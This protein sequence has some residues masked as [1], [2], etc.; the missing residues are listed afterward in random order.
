MVLSLLHKEEGEAA[1]GPPWW[2][3]KKAAR[4]GSLSVPPAPPPLL[5]ASGNEAASEGCS[6]GAAP[7][8]PVLS[9][10]G[11]GAVFGSHIEAPN[12][13]SPTK[14]TCAHQVQGEPARRGCYHCH[15]HF[16]MGKQVQGD[17]PL[18]GGE[19]AIGAQMDG[20]PGFRC[21]EM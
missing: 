13:W 8:A 19:A 20:R 14:P 11:A 1:R 16:Q 9:V 15:S 5:W 10:G 6:L 17:A 21:A 3:G 18:A 7:L 12:L 4:N 2:H